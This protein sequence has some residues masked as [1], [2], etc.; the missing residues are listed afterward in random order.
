M[1]HFL[2]KR[3]FSGVFWVFES[4]FFKKVL[5][6]EILENVSYINEI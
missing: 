4:Y 5:S 6:F 3:V 1:F 2:I